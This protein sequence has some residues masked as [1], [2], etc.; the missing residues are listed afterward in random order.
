MTWHTSYANAN[1]QV[2]ISATLVTRSVRSSAVNK[3]VGSAQVTV[4]AGHFQ[5][6]E[7]V[8][9]YTTDMP[10]VSGGAVP[11]DIRYRGII[12]YYWAKGVGMIEVRYTTTSS[13]TTGNFQAP[14]STYTV[15]RELTTYS[16][17]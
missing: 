5:A 3:V 1:W 15:Y 13:V 10:A 12:T 14:P 9:T 7:I 6:V 2:P 16:L 8:Q 4:P 17:H 11:A